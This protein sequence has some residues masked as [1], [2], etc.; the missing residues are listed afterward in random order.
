MTALQ[1]PWGAAR[2]D[3]R[4][5]TRRA[6]CG[7][8]RQATGTS[9]GQTTWIPVRLFHP[10]R[11]RGDGG[12]RRC[13]A[14]EDGASVNGVIGEPPGNGQHSGLH[15]GS[16]EEGHGVAWSQPRVGTLSF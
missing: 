8:R 15:D 10:I 2:S 6:S 9:V 7:W 16:G 12:A 11:A 1:F 13:Q 14:C 4:C 3:W 5:L